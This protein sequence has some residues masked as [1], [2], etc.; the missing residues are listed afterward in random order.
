MFSSRPSHTVVGE[1]VRADL[2]VTNNL[3][4]I[5]MHLKQVSPGY[6][7]LQ[8]V[9]LRSF[10]SSMLA[11]GAARAEHAALRIGYLYAVRCEAITAS[12]T[13]PGTL[14]LLGV[15]GV[16]PV[17]RGEVPMQRHASLVAAGGV[18]AS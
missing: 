18:A 15:Q 14:Y 6:G 12:P 3:P 11:A 1:L 17:V 9:A 4:T 13:A 10:P 8:V 16:A 2:D 5:T 7:A